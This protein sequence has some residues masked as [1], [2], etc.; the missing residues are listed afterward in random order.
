MAARYLPL[1]TN[2]WTGDLRPIRENGLVGESPF[3]GNSRKPW[4]TLF[5]SM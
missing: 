3:Y 1:A 2:P 5:T 4:F